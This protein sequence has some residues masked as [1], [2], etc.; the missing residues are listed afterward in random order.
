MTEI[1]RPVPLFEEYYEI[2]NFGNVQS[3]DRVIIQKCRGGGE[4][5][6]KYKGQPIKFRKSL[7]GYYDFSARGQGRVKNFNVHRAVALAF[8]ANPFNYPM[9]NHINGDKLNNH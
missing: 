4:R 5:S 3:L 8:I 7:R 6:H 9:V 2:S 1:W